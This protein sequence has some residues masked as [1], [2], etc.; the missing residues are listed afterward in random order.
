MS[1]ELIFTILPFD[2]LI[3]PNLEIKLPIDVDDLANQFRK[4]FPDADVDIRQDNETT[5]I[6][7]YIS[8]EKQGPWIITEFSEDDSILHV[9]GWP[10]RIAK[11]LVFWY[12]GH[13]PQTYPLFLVIADHGYVAELTASTTLDDIENM[14][15]FPVPDD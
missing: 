3:V 15:P 5:D 1:H 10:K 7:V 8:T 9:N 12:R 13:I 6:R 4:K 11:E 14:Y 2:P